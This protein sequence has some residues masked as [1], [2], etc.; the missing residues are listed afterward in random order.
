MNDSPVL[1]LTTSGDK[2]LPFLAELRQMAPIVIGERPRDFAAS[3][4]AKILLNW[5]GSLPLLRD[6][7]LMP[8]PAILSVIGIFRQLLAFN[9]ERSC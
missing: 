9:V 1:V 3:V 7:F 8:S 6:V 2:N 5:S 4:D